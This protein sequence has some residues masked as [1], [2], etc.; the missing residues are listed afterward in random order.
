MRA[1]FI[2]FGSR[3]S[4]SGALLSLAEHAAQYVEPE[5][6]REIATLNLH[7]DRD[8]VFFALVASILAHLSQEER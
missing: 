4:T 6:D 1:E 2:S 3:W 8:V 7:V 5:C